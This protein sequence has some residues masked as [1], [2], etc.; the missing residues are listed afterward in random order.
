M[1]SKVTAEETIRLKRVADEPWYWLRE[2]VPEVAQWE[3]DLYAFL[4]SVKVVW[5]EYRTNRINLAFLVNWSKST[6]PTGALNINDV[7]SIQQ[8]QNAANSRLIF[9]VDL[10]GGILDAIDIGSE[11]DP[12]SIKIISQTREAVVVW[13]GDNLDVFYKGMR[14]DP[15][16]KAETL[17]EMKLKKRDQLLALIDYRQILNTHYEQYV[18]GE[19]GFY[20]WFPGEKNKVLQSSPERIFQKNLYMFLKN[21][22]ECDASLEPMFKDSSRCDVRASMDYD[23][24]FFEIKWIG[25]CATKKKGSAVISADKPR[26]E[27][28]ENAIAGAYQTKEYIES[29]NSI[30]YDNKLKLGVVVVYDGYPE[31]RI[32][33]T[34]PPEITLSPL[35]ETAEFALVTAT[36]STIGKKLAKQW[37]R[38][39]K[40]R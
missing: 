24:Y 34:Y 25:F 4:E 38:S 39:S 30:Q 29:N 20:Y 12:T 22:C 36:P 8:V 32:P 31:A 14:W 9:E 33:I 13:F 16:N 2:N 18:R 15:K 6:P 7:A 26:E 5:Q 11:I 35:L 40:K 21:E 28:V 27:R 19:A 17:K 1:T 3:K 10:A 37:R 23:I